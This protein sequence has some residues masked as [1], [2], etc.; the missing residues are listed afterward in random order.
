MVF[1]MIGLFY[2][3]SKSQLKRRSVG[4]FYKLG[5]SRQSMERLTIAQQEGQ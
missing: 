4:F 2:P 1:L 5:K 3:D